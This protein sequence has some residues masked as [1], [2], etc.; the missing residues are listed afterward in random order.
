MC[1]LISFG[2]TS[3]SEI[4]QKV[5]RV[6]A[7]IANCPSERL[8]E[9]PKKLNG[10]VS[11]LSPPNTQGRFFPQGCFNL[12]Q[13]DGHPSILSVA[14]KVSFSQS[15]DSTCILVSAFSFTTPGDKSTNSPPL[16]QGL[17][18]PLCHSW[19]EVQEQ[20]ACW[21]Q[22]TIGSMPDQ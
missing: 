22:K 2:G 6:L 5:F 4:P 18:S 16:G 10:E 14:V 7:Y 17:G 1:F 20:R 13:L 3:K 8:C 15:G 9:H 12:C 21:A 19:T 11:S